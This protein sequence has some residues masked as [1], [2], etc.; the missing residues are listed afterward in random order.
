VMDYAVRRALNL[1][2]QQRQARGCTL[3]VIWPQEETQR[4]G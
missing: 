1:E 3:A 2:L 4:Q